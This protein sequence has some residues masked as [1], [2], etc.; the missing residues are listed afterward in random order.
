VKYRLIARQQLGKHIHAQADARNNR[1]SIARQ[2]NIKLA[3]IKIKTV[4]S[5]WSVKNGYKE[6]F[7][8]ERHVSPP[9]MPGIQ[10]QGRPPLG[11]DPRLE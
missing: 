3:F 6:V 7:S 10:A 8:L 4:F 11:H 5:A 9:R 1:M 2:R